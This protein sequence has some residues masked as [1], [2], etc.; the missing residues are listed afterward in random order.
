M[1]KQL[2]IK[3]KNETSS[4]FGWISRDVLDEIDDRLSFKRKGIEYSQKVIDGTWDG[5]SHCFST[6][7]KTFPTGLCKMVCETLDRN[8]IPWEIE[9]LRNEPSPTE[10]WKVELPPPIALYDFQ[11]ETVDLCKDVGRGICSLPTGSGKTMTFSVLIGELNVSPVIV[12]VPSLLLLDQTKA[13]LEKIIRKPDGSPMKVGMIGNGVCDIREINV[14]TIQ[15]AITVYDKVYD[16][17]KGC[18]RDLTRE[19]KA[20]R[21]QRKRRSPEDP[22]RDEDLNFINP[23]RP[24]IKELIEGAQVVIADECH[25]ASSAMYQEVMGNSKSA[26]YRFAFSATAFREDNTEILIQASFGRKLIDIS[27][28]ELIRRGVLVR[29]YIFSVSVPPESRSKFESYQQ[30]KKRCIVESVQRNGLIADLA[31]RLKDEGPTLLLVT[32][33]RHGRALEQLIPN[34]KFIHAGDPK[35][36]KDET[37]SDMLS[38]K[39]PVMIATPIADEGLDLVQLKVLFL[40]DAG[41]SAT[42]LYQRVG[43]SLRSCPGKDYSIIIDFKDTDENLSDHVSDRRH[44]FLNEEEFVLIDVS[45]N[46]WDH[47]KD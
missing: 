6:Y 46:K 1:S 35:K 23:N 15:T 27:C 2:I 33:K 25:R 41:Q 3:I 31:S 40:C 29:P 34:S 4:I 14:M 24:K 47:I 20:K 44:L 22:D 38:G 16:R 5:R 13:V 32:E 42:K 19:E 9:D 36:V 43:R 28:S 39:L 26:Y 7:Y 8:H 21:K 45:Q 10:N 30:A 17:N 12:Y 11:R 18:V 37:I